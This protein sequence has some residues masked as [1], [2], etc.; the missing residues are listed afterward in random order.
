MSNVKKIKTC[1]L[2]TGWKSQHLK[3]ITGFLSD[4]YKHKAKIL[5]ILNWYFNELIYNGF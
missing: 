2:W 1:F 4:H 5:K 3:K